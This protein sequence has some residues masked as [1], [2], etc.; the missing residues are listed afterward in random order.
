M[1]IKKFKKVI[2]VVIIIIIFSLGFYFYR[3]K[4][5]QVEYI[6]TKVIRGNLEQTVTATGRVE[7]PSEV[8]LKFEIPGKLKEVKVKVGQSVKTGEILAELESSDIEI[9]VAKSE[10]ALTLA[11]ANLDQK[12]AGESQENIEITKKEVAKAQAAVSKAETDLANAKISLE[13]VKNSNVENIKVAELTLKDTQD[14]LE[15]AEKDLNNTKKTYSQARED[16]YSD[17]KTTMKSNLITIS[18][19]MTDMDNILGVDNETIND[20][21]EN[22]LGIF[23]P[24]TKTDAKDFYQKAKNSQTQTELVVNNLTDSSSHSQISEAISQVKETLSKVTEALTKTRILLD[25]STTNTVLTQTQINSYKTTLDTN[26]T[27]INTAL[28]NLETN[29]QAISTAE[30]TEE[31]KVD[32]AESAYQNSENS[33]Q[34]AK[35]NLSQVKIQAESNEDAAQAKVDS[36]ELDLKIYKETMAAALATLTLKEASPREVDLK[37]F[38]AQV[39]EAKTLLALSRDKL[40]K[41]HLLAPLD[42]VITQVNFARGEQVNTTETVIVII[43]ISNFEIEVDISEAD[44]AKVDLDDEV[45]ITLDAFSEEKKFQGKVIFIDPAETV[46]QDVIY[47]QVKVSLMTE[48]KQIKSGMTADVTIKTDEKKNVLLVPERTISETGGDKNVK[49][50]NKGIVKEII[51]TTGL[52]G[53]GGLVEIITGLEEGEEVVTYEKNNNK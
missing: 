25:N 52:K 37:P 6:T 51:I 13:N 24:Q 5:S 14:K 47:Y 39:E 46:I 32:S 20:S 38:R 8:D 17:A 29:D 26:R 3:H 53:D 48:E 44:I 49:V 7:S 19:A 41:A 11:V 4:K 22:V 35:Q 30:L 34:Q 43:G 50:I 45:E 23:N 28:S 18:Q 36:Y 21:F 16:A 27:N 2:L 12:L 15:N 33:Y 31:S 40:N 9:E 1:N 10:A 42:G